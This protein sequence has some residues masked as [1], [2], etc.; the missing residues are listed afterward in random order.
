MRRFLL[1]VLGLIGSLGAGEAAA[2]PAG[3][4]HPALADGPSEVLRMSLPKLGVGGRDLH[5]TMLARGGRFFAGYAQPSGGLPVFDRI[6]VAPPGPHRIIDTASGTE[7]DYPASLYRRYGYKDQDFK[8][9]R[10]RYMAGTLA[11]QRYDD[12]PPLTWDASARTLRGTMDVLLSNAQAGEDGYAPFIRL[13]L[14]MTGG[15]RGTLSGSGRWHAYELKDQTYGAKASRT[16]IRLTAKWDAEAWKPVPGSEFAPGKDWPQQRGP[17]LNGSAI[18]CGR[19]LVDSILDARIAWIA[20]EVMPGQKGGVNKTPFG[21]GSIVVNDLTTGG[22]AAP[23]VV[24]GRVYFWYYFPDLDWLAAHS[25]WGAG[26]RDPKSVDPNT[27]ALWV[28]GAPMGHDAMEH[29]LSVAVCIDARTGQTLWRRTEPFTA[30]KLPDEKQMNGLTPVVHAGK[31]IARTPGALVCWDAK[32]GRELWRSKEYRM[33]QRKIYWSHDESLAVIGGTL[34]VA[35]AQD[36][37]TG[38]DGLDPATGAKKWSQKEVIGGN[39]V[40]SKVQLDGRDYILSAYGFGG[41]MSGSQIG[42]DEILKRCR[43][44][45]IDPADGRILWE[46]REVGNQYNSLTVVGDIACLNGGRGGQPP[47]DGQDMNAPASGWRIS[48]RGAQKL[49]QADG[50]EYWQ[51]R[52]NPL[53]QAGSFLL[54]SRSTGFN[55]VDAVSGRVLGKE[56]HIYKQTGGDHNWTWAV[57]SDGRVISSG[58]LMYDASPLKLRPGQL[59]IRAASGYTCPILPALADGRLIFRTASH[60]ICLDLRKP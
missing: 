49:W 34:L 32:D 6:E 8:A 13:E 12:P 33:N 11:M 22:Y 23:C 55:G 20:E 47:G 25:P 36:G 4:R 51:T 57:G 21:M 59:H 48:L 2:K 44:V 17:H 16:E 15:E 50:V 42:A 37:G 40:P 35:T 45:L 58:L 26:P 54:D 43:M 27:Y 41:Q 39:A 19:P 18:D 28:R 14:D 29:Y 46:Q 31:L 52:N 5:L 9:L 24:D 7:I 10:E 1:V 56:Q 30:G 60:L 38:L 53:G 3:S